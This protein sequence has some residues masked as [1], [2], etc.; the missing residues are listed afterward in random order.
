MYDRWMDGW[1]DGLTDEMCMYANWN[2]SWS[3]TES[4][5]YV[6]MFSGCDLSHCLDC[7]RT[8]FN[9]W[10]GLAWLM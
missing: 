7:L 9:V 8:R 6:M 2:C 1:M 5:T 3:G 10:F 4:F